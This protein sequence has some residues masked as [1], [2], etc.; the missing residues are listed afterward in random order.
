MDLSHSWWEFEESVTIFLEGC[1]KASKSAQ[2]WF[3]GSLH[4]FPRKML[5]RIRINEAFCSART[6]SRNIYMSSKNFE[7]HGYM[8]DLDLPITLQ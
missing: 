1:I 3:D 4:D 6:C 8:H 5:Q 2:G 7:E